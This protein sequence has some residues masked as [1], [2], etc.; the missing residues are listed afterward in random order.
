MIQLLNGAHIIQ[1][2]ADGEQGSVRPPAEVQF[3]AKGGGH[4]LLRLT[5][6]PRCGTHNDAIPA[7]II[8]GEATVSWA[9]FQDVKC[10]PSHRRN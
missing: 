4:G 1:V 10:V 5:M 3:R 6:V 9:V 8:V 7:S 2:Q